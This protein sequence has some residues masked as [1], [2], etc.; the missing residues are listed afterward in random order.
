MATSIDEAILEKRA[1]MCYPSSFESSSMVRLVLSDA[2]EVSYR[3]LRYII[4]VESAGGGKSGREAHKANIAK[5][6]KSPLYSDAAKEYCA[7]TN[8]SNE[9]I[10]LPAHRFLTEKI[11]LSYVENS[12]FE[13]RRN[14]CIL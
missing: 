2:D 6:F 10:F 3:K 14:S 8:L 11:I 5:A 9:L 4:W 12:G 7:A 1:S 13:L